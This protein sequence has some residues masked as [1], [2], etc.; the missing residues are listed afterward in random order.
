LST[1]VT[2]FLFNAMMMKLISEDGVAA[3]TIIIYSQ[4]LLTSLY[5]GFSMGVAPIISYNYGS[6][7]NTQ[8]NHVFKICILFISVAS[9]L[10]FIFSISCSPIIVE[11]FS[12]RGS[13]V[14]E[15]AR[16]G[17]YIFSFSFIFCGYN[18]FTSSMFTAL[19]NG[20]VSAILSFLRTFGF[21][22]IGLLILPNMLNINGIWLAVP[23]AEILTLFLTVFCICKHK[24]RYKYM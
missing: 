9:L 8:L 17:F 23:S 13:R 3:I 16:S 14:Y 1:A 2:T 11:I 21:I 22:T 19:S 18:I 7:N 24:N 20:K 6:E 15:I 5:I 4:F 10:V 12:Q